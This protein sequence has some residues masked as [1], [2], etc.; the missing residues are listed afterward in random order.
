[1]ICQ[2]AHREQDSGRAVKD[3]LDPIPTDAERLVPHV[4]PLEP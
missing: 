4:L 1:M 3:T 2:P